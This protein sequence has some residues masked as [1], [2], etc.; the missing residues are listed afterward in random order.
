MKALKPTMTCSVTGSDSRGT[1]DGRHNLRQGSYHWKKSL[2]A[3]SCA[4]REVI[5]HRSVNVVFCEGDSFLRLQVSAAKF[6]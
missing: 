1:I 3:I 5:P 4:D 6:Y 2:Q